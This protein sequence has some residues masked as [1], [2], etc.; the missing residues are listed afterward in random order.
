MQGRRAAFDI[1]MLC[2]AIGTL[3]AVATLTIQWQDRSAAAIRATTE[4]TI[5]VEQMASR[6]ADLVETAETVLQL[7][8]KT[9]QLERRV[10]D[11][12]A[13]VR[14][15]EIEVAR[16]KPSREAVLGNSR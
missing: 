6:V 9:R 1:T 7:D 3:V 4:T 10:G 11:L 14:D 8:E 16:E 15:L 12:E 2:T 5:R 13:K